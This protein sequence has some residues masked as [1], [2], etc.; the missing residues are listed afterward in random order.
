[1]IFQ[2]LKTGK[3]LTCEDN[4]SILNVGINPEELKS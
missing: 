3:K 2:K 1:M 4:T